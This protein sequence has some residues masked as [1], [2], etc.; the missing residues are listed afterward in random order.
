MPLLRIVHGALGA[1]LLLAA[2]GGNEH[3][4]PDAVPDAGPCW[5]LTATPGG[6]V[7]LGTGDITFE[8]MPAVLPIINNLSQSDPHLQ[9]HAR[10]RGFPPG[11]PNDAFDPRNPRTMLGAEIP[12][13]G[14]V[15]N[16]EIQ[17][18]ASLAYVASPEPGAFDLVH[19]IPRGFG[20]F[21]IGQASGKQAHITIEVVGSNGLYAKDERL[22]TLMIMSGAAAP[23]AGA[24]VPVDGS[25]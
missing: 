20:N 4:A 19:S 21:P 25:P 11:N 12:E 2:C 14:L 3:P 15:L 24:P 10:I 7:E 23:G 13:L 5:P 17:C 9:L 16:P 6:Q 8:P 22:V 1:G 18:P